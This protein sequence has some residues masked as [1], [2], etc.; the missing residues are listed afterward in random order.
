M[1]TMKKLITIP[2]MVASLI[3]VV[4]VIQ[5]SCSTP[6]ADAAMTSTQMVE[7]GTYMV[8]AGGCNDCHSPKIM[9]PHGPVVDS[10]KLLSGSPDGMPL[11]AIDPAAISPGKWYLASADLT[12]WAGPWGISYT[13]NLTPDSM[14]GTGAW[15]EELFLKILHTG[16][17]MGIDAGR[18]VMPPMPWE[19]IGK[20]TDQDLKCI[21]AYLRTVKPVRN[22]VHAYV[23]PPEIASMNAP[24]K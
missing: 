4:I 8:N 18:P 12:A 3:G 24:G 6:P 15:T 19:S 2:L 1:N 14:T 5:T 13:A 16:K 11:A 22:N 21:F 9:T 10:S 7:R 20:M 23:S 17:F